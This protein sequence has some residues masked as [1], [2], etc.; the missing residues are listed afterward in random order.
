MVAKN[1][2]S[3]WLSSCGALALCGLMLA[4]CKT[5]EQ[6][7]TAPEEVP[8]VDLVVD[9]D[10]Q[11][12][13]ALLEQAGLDIQE[14]AEDLPEGTKIRLRVNR[15]GDGKKDVEAK[16]EVEIPGVA[17]DDLLRAIEAS[18]RSANSSFG[19]DITVSEGLLDLE[20]IPT[21]GVEAETVFENLEA[22]S[23]KRPKSLP[24]TSS[25][26]RRSGIPSSTPT[27]EPPAPEVAQAESEETASA[28]P[29][30][31]G[32]IATSRNKLTADMDDLFGQSSILSR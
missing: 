7:Q 11:D 6:A 24:S 18:L 29:L 30:D 5:T 16:R 13:R 1:P 10:D 22:T 20:A 19:E 14:L 23:R 27:T 4:S 15:R 32:I 12:A 31:E 21:V 17:D 9:G 2:R 26:P 3:K 8:S 25:R 28:D